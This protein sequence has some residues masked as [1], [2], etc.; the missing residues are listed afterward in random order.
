MESIGLGKESWGGAAKSAELLGIWCLK[1]ALPPLLASF[2][3]T[4]HLL[5]F[6]VPAPRLSLC[7]SWPH[8]W[9]QGVKRDSNPPLLPQWAGHLQICHFWNWGGKPT[10]GVRCGRQSY[11]Q[12]T[13]GTSIL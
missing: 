1:I 11:Q 5:F 6:S 12:G 10:G 8:M 4:G 2:R 13:P 3:G 7:L 9:T